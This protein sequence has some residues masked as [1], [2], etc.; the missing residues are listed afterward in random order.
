LKCYIHFNTSG[1][2][3]KGGH[4]SVVNGLS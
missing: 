3:Y 2:I 4:Q 1:A